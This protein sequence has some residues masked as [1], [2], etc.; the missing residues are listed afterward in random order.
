[1]P[2]PTYDHLP[3]H[4]FGGLK[5]DSCTFEEARAAVLPVPLERT[6]SYMSGTRHGPR[7][8]L[9]ASSQMELW[10]EET[11]T[12]AEDL[13]IFT[14]PEMELPFAGTG[15]ALAEVTRVAGEIIDRDKFL[16]VL[17]GEHSI[18]PAVVKAMAGRTGDLSVLQIDAHAD[19]RD[20]YMGNPHSHASAM[21][22]VLEHAPLTQVAVRSM[23]R[24]EALELPRLATR[25]FFDH[26]MRDDPGWMDA[27]VESLGPHVYLTIDCD[28][29]DPA[30][31]PAVGTPEPGGLNWREALGLLR[32]VFAEREVVG[33]DIVELCPLPGLVAPNFLCAR[34]VFKILAYRLGTALGPR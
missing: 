13:G 16:V 27:V 29:F 18:T 23:S 9:L 34:L 26:D 24:D 15:E 8:I 28:G 32:K 1:M 30:I 7:E 4:L 12:N 5:P 2:I 10:D 14:L 3:A 22:R 6:T 33:A 11:A 20:A 25:V 19:L 17:G 21:R 31:M